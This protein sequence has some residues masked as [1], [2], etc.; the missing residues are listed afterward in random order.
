M[1][2]SWR[3]RS[4]GALR[5]LARHVRGMLHRGELRRV[6]LG[7][8]VAVAA[9]ATGALSVTVSAASNIDI[10]GDWAGVTFA[11]GAQF[12]QDL[13]IT[14]EDLNTGVFSGTDGGGA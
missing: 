2:P 4:V 11:L 14:S 5:H 10:R 13:Y 8:A 6:M 3:G 1:H 12:P 9:V 7:A